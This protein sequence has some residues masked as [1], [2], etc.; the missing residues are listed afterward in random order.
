MAPDGRAEKPFPPVDAAEFPLLQTFNGSVRALA[1]SPTGDRLYAACNGR[2]EEQKGVQRLVGFD[3]ETGRAV[4]DS[5]LSE[6]SES[7]VA[8]QDGA[9]LLRGTRAGALEVW[10]VLPR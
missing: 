8:S 9:L 7:L 10:G 1:F 5:R 4:R 2:G 6:N 3:P